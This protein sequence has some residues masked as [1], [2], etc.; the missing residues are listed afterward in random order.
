MPR[1]LFDATMPQVR[2]IEAVPTFSRPPSRHDRLL[3]C[4]RSVVWDLRRLHHCRQPMHLD[5]HVL[6]PNKASAHKMP[7]RGGLAVPRVS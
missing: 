2:A 3:R 1:L 6:H 7:P 4:H 5:R